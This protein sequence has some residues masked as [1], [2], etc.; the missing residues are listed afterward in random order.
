MLINKILVLGGSG[1]LGSH[2]IKSL[3]VN[4]DF[5]VTNGDIKEDKTL[6]CDFIPFDILDNNKMQETLSNYNTV[7]NCVGQVTEPINLCFKINSEGI[8]NLSRNN[9][10]IK[11]RL[12]HISTVSVYGS[13]NFCDENSKLN[14]ETPYAMAKA[15]SERILIE[16]FNEKDLVILRLPNLYG[17]NQQKGIFAYLLKSYA[18]DRKLNFNNNGKLYRSYIHAD[19][20]SAIIYK[21]VTNKNIMGIYNV[22][23]N[24][25][26]SVKNLVENLERELDIIFE[27]NFNNNHS[28]ENI[29]HL[30][31]SKLKSLIDYDYRWNFSE[32]FKNEIDYD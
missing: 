30:D 5:H 25:K 32:F 17:F 6:N 23:G 31:G 7:I 3:Q 16:N 13:A 8:L 9:D 28:W 12:I 27:K 22:E 24:Q 4:T 1:F 11:F 2:I 14:P 18:T 15:Y 20:C 19:D 26:I 21:V 10:L 29:K